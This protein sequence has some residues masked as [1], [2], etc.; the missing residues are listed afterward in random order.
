MPAAVSILTEV[1]ILMRT[2]ADLID[3]T[4][5]GRQ[6]QALFDYRCG[7]ALSQKT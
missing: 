3:D 1:L 5:D 2:R 7:S 6:A 4:N